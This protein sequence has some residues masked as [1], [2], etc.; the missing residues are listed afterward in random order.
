MY[1]LYYY[2]NGPIMAKVLTAIAYVTN[3]SSYGTLIQFVMILAGVLMIAAWHSDNVRGGLG[4]HSLS[5]S[6]LVLATLYYGGFAPKTDLVVNDPLNSFV[7]SVRNMPQGVGITLWVSNKIT[8]GFADLFDAAF[9]SSGFPDEFTYQHSGGTP[10][11]LL[12]VSAIGRI[13]PNDAYLF[14]TIENYIRKCYMTAVL[15]GQKNINNIRDSANL[16]SELQTNLSGSWWGIYYSESYPRGKSEKCTD[17]YNDMKNDLQTAVAAGGSVSKQLYY[18]LK[19]LGA[20]GILS[21]GD[22]E[23]LLQTAGN[24]MLAGSA[25]SQSMLAQA[26]LINALNP[27]MLAFAE[28]SGFNPEAFNMA[29]TQSALNTTATMSTSYALASTFLPLS[30]LVVNSFVMSILPLTFALMFVPSMTRKYGT[31]AFD[32]LMWMAFWGPIASIINFIIQSYASV[33]TSSVLGGKITYSMFPFL[34]AHTHTLMAIAGDIMFSVPVLAFALASGSTYAMTTATGAVAGLSK[35]AAAGASS[36]MTTATGIRQEENAA[37]ENL[38]EG[39]A[40]KDAGY[41]NKDVTKGLMDIERGMANYGAAQMEM[42]RNFVNDVMV[43]RIAAAGE[44]NL[45]ANL[46]RGEGYD[47]VHQAERAGRLSTDMNLANVM[48]AYGSY[49][50]AE[51]NGYKGSFVQWAEQSAEYR[52]TNAVTQAEEMQ[53]MA[54]KYFGGNLDSEM[55]FINSMRSAEAL[56]DQFGEQQAYDL[57]KRHG[58]RGTLTDFEAYQRKFQSATGIAMATGAVAAAGGWDSAYNVKQKASA[59]DIAKEKQ[60]FQTFAEQNHIPDD[61]KS[62]MDFGITQ[63][64]YSG[65]QIEGL[66]RYI[67]SVGTDQVALTQLSERLNEWGKNKEL[68]VAASAMGMSLKDFVQYKHSMGQMVLSK[69]AAERLSELTGHKFTAGERVTWAFNPK[70]GEVGWAVGEK[71]YSTTNQ[72][73]YRVLKYNETDTQDKNRYGTNVDLGNAI[74]AHISSGE[75]AKQLTRELLKPNMVGFMRTNNEDTFIAGAMGFFNK[76]LS[77]VDTKYGGKTA[78]DMSKI[79]QK[80]DES[81]E[82]LNLGKGLSAFTGG[83]IGASAGISHSNQSIKKDSSSQGSNYSSTVDSL[84]ENFRKEAVRIY[85][86]TKNIEDPAERTQIRAAL[87]SSSAEKELN[88]A[89]LSQK[90]GFKGATSTNADVP[91]MGPDSS[92]KPLPAYDPGQAYI[93]KS[94]LLKQLTE[95]SGQ[96]EKKTGDGQ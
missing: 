75:S 37:K 3:S 59:S 6:F 85:D 33:T 18:F 72:D 39:Q 71:G 91:V 83:V 61:L 28:Q 76:V 51:S 79:H 81:H 90:S 50:Q 5:V 57:A 13:T 44:K 80:T 56:G 10:K 46:G 82:S 64:L 49:R 14:M 40:V 63:G 47:S 73:V 62:A 4:A 24:Y 27:E 60:Q 32:L 78:S 11:A 30:F 12:T 8:N 36:R 66:E 17:L 74:D 68:R 15:L 19:S 41:S 95:N 86:M 25:S 16:L 22:A 21:D 35:S 89:A 9:E 43:K 96:W 20:P 67:Q 42:Y 55:R 34:M 31:M 45:A 93:D 29:I 7:T 1:E 69:P 52:N 23:N 84:R 2:G 94:K 87:M 53:K 26:V 92:D 54:D 58:F 48:G 77:V 88:S 70:T 38:S 65:A